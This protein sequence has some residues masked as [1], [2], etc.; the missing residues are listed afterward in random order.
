MAEKEINLS[1]VKIL[2]GVSGG[3]AAYKAIDLASKLIT[4]GAQ[5]HVVV[6]DNA[7][8]M[9]GPKR[10]EAITSCCTSYSKHYR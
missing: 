9:V 8:Q 1:C 2:L 6:T 7:C 3:I 4:A 5:V 10:F